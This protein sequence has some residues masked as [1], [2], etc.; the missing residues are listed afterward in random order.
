MK[1]ELSFSTDGIGT[2]AYLHTEKVNFDL[3]L[4]TEQKLTQNDHRSKGKT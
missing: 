4:T 2:T 1:E 3:N